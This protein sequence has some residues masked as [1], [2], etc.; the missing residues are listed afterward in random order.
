M[1]NPINYMDKMMINQKIS[2]YDN[3]TPYTKY[4]LADYLYGKYIGAGNEMLYMVLFREDNTMIDC[5][6]ISEGSLNFAPV[7]P[8]K[9]LETAISRKAARVLIAHNHPTGSASPSEEDARTT[10]S[11]QK[12]FNDVGIDFIDHVII[13][14]ERYVFLCD[15]FD[16]GGG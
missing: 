11:L 10:N 13:S 12:M 16:S 5:V 3:T 15:G 8:R 6:K 1:D 14:P 9:M 7:L 4:D 2:F